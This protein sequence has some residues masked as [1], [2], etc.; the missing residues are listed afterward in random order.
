MITV[1]IN[2]LKDNNCGYVSISFE[3]ITFYTEILTWIVDFFTGFIH[4]TALHYNFT[5]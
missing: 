5:I 1:N 3:K 2:F 4:E